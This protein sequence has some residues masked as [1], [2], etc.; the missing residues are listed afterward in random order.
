MPGNFSAFPATSTT[1]TQL[2]IPPDDHAKDSRPCSNQPESSPRPFPFGPKPEATCGFPLHSQLFCDIQRCLK[3]PRLRTWRP[4]PPWGPGTAEPAL[5]QCLEVCGAQEL[6][7]DSGSSTGTTDCAL[8]SPPE[9]DPMASHSPMPAQWF[10]GVHG[11][12]RL[13]ASH[14]AQ[15]S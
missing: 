3:C 8:S 14:L 15:W 6:E 13:P 2:S 5:L 9:W 7:P 11:A 10:R 12:V 1:T 4:W